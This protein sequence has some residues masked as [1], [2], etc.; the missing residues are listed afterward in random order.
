MGTDKKKLPRFDLYDSLLY[1]DRVSDFMSRPPITLPP[2]AAMSQAKELMRR[3]RITGIPIVDADGRLAGLV[4]LENLIIALE[5]NEIREA[6]SEH[7]VRNVV[8]LRDTMRV[9]SLIEC[10]M[11]YDYGRY[12]VIDEDDRVVGVLTHGDVILHVLER[13]GNVYLHDRKREEV[14]TPSHYLFNPSS[15]EPAQTFAYQ[16]D[17]TDIDRA[18]EGSTLFKK[19]LQKQGFP[20]E[21]ARRA[22]IAL[23][24]AEVNV[25][26]HAYGKGR[27]TAHLRDGQLFVVV[28][29]SGPGIEDIEQ[30]MKPGYSTAT[31]EARMRG[32]GAGM[33]LA[34]IRKYTDKLVILSGS[35]G[36]KV[37]MMILARDRQ[38]AVVSP[39]RETK[40]VAPR[41]S[42]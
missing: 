23:Y 16:I 28:S 35:A 36:L 38:P 1:A 32:F 34:N 31:E 9:T 33:G 7:M 27:I 5:K 39:E 21:D 24:E 11:T 15:Y 42:S 25:V 8:C 19:F 3:H 41:D 37:E 20:P 29:D 13:L 30:A 12:P 14:L 40:A 6:V 22:S 4:S 2:E 26:L 17:T 10:L 18:G